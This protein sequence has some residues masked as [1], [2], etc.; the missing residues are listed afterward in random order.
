VTKADSAADDP[1]E[2][3]HITLISQSLTHSLPSV[4]SRLMCSWTPKRDAARIDT[5]EKRNKA[6]NRVTNVKLNAAST[7]MH[8]CFRILI[9][10]VNRREEPFQ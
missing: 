8:L 10:M 4:S 2:T 3:V 7:T 6:L 9:K 5:V 1:K